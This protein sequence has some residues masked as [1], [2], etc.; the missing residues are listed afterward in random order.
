MAEQEFVV[1]TVWKNFMQYGAQKGQPYWTFVLDDGSRLPCYDKK[2]VSKLGID[3]TEKKTEFEEGQQ[4]PLV[5][6]MR[7]DKTVIVG[8]QDDEDESED[9][10]EAEE[11]EQDEEEEKPKKKYA[12]KKPA[13][14][15]QP[16]GRYA[17]RGNGSNKSPEERGEIM[18]M[19]VLRTAVDYVAY[20]KVKGLAQLQDATSKFEAYVKD[21]KFPKEVPDKKSKKAAA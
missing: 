19:N 10:E 20:Q 8:L 5:V 1:V 17:G 2:V 13:K 16:A 12:V 3:V 15:N 9:E 4:M 7:K 14:F 18:R 11:N 21:G 6:E